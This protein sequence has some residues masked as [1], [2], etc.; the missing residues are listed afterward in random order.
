MG[1]KW[2]GT[3]PTGRLCFPVPNGIDCLKAILIA[4]KHKPRIGDCHMAFAK[5]RANGVMRACEQSLARLEKTG[6]T[7]GSGELNKLLDLASGAT[8]LTDEMYLTTEDFAAIKD[9]WSPVS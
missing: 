2:F 8:A 7:A 6:K 9:F 5:F 3:R 1:S 4:G